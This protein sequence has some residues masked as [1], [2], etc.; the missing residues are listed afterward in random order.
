[1]HSDSLLK[2]YSS[3]KFISMLSMMPGLK[4]ASG[5]EMS[6]LVSLEKHRKKTG[7]VGVEPR[8]MS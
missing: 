5:E 2:A 4:N 8:V 6:Y 7:L 3:Q 1:M